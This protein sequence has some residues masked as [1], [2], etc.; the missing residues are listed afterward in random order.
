[1]LGQVGLER[2]RPERCGVGTELDLVHE[3]GTTGQVEGDLDQGLV[4]GHVDRGE[5]P[6]ARFVAQCFPEGL[7]EQDA[8]ILAYSLFKG[9][10]PAGM[11][12]LPT[13]TEALSTIKFVSAKPAQ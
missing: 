12:E 2:G 10:Y 1:M 6:D 8:D 7:T 11:S 4:E 5:A 13:Q 9:N 3:I